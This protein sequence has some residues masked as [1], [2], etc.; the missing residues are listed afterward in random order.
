MR[1][2]TLIVLP[3]EDF[4]VSTEAQEECMKRYKKRMN[5]DQ[6]ITSCDSCKVILL[7]SDLPNPEAQLCARDQRIMDKKGENSP[8]SSRTTFYKSPSSTHAVEEI[9]LQK[10]FY[11]AQSSVYIGKVAHM[12]HP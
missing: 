3:L 11:T 7:E 1:L 5:D 6:R 12:P 8:R 2:P 9:L 4:S 10:V